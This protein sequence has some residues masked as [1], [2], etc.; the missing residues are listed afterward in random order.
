MEQKDIGIVLSIVGAMMLPLLFWLF[1]LV[2]MYACTYVCAYA[3]ALSIR[4][5]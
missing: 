3:H 1:P 2:R 5:S 4:G